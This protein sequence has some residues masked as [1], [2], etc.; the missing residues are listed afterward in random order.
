VSVTL[1]V[2]LKR[3]FSHF[4]KRKFQMVEVYSFHYLCDELFHLPDST[5][6]EQFYQ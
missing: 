4:E 5:V 6:G 1:P 2:V 3:I